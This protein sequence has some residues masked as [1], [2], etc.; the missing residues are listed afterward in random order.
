[1]VEETTGLHACCPVCTKTIATAERAEGMVLN[2]HSCGS[3]IGATIDPD[4]TVVTKV[5]KNGKKARKQ[6]A[7]EKTNQIN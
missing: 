2:C 6:Y 7:A 1:M 4:G 5:I 3:I